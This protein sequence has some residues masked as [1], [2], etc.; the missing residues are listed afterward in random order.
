MGQ[1]DTKEDL[2]EKIRHYQAIPM[3]D[4]VLTITPW[5]RIR[6]AEEIHDQGLG[7]GGHSLRPAEARSYFQ[8]PCPS[9]SKFGEERFLGKDRQAGRKTSPSI[10]M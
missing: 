5:G 9:I 7:Y 8:E 3:H 4:A 1:I 2:T 6:Q 10:S